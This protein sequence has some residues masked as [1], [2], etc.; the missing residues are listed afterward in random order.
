MNNHQRPDNA[1]SYQSP[2]EQVQAGQSP[3]EAARQAA[4]MNHH[5][6]ISATPFPGTV[7]R[8][9]AAVYLK[10]VY[11]LLA[12]S[13]AVSVAAGFVGMR[14][15]FAYEH[16]IIM[17]VLFFGAFLLA[18][19]VQNTPTL[20]LFTA[21]AG[22]SIGPVIG[23]YVGAGLSHIVGQAVFM[24]GAAFGGLS[25]YALTTKKDLSG[26]GGM[27]FAGL[28]VLI[29]GGLVNLF[30]QSTALSFAFSAVGAVIFSGLIL[31]ETQQLRNN[32][33]AIPPSAAA[34]SMFLNVFNLFLS[35][36]RLLGLMGGED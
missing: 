31:W 10:Q 29:V 4:A 11:A 26:I 25:F 17:M 34:L 6:R 33:W 7:S 27:L 22:F 14:T 20:F 9:D 1:S 3:T 28:I 5:D 15:P 12:A 2:W 30:L 23:A 21:V 8:S 35:L 16:P 36:L 19:A 32:P 13:L 24:T 18:R